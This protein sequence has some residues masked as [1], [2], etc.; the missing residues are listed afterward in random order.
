[1][2]RSKI[3]IIDDEKD[4]VRLTAKRLR[5]VGHEVICHFE[6]RGAVDLIRATKPDVILL[7][8]KLP[9]VS[10]TDIFKKIRGDKELKSIPIVLFSASISQMG[11][12]FQEL[13]ADGFL[14]KPYDP[15]TLHDVINRTMTSRRER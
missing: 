6:G 5:S 15:Q 14:P 9:D 8:I 7:D 3:L 4:L 2:R 11:R 1:M 13:D 10:A 12:L